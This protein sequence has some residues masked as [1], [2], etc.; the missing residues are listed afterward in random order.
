MRARRVDTNHATVKKAFKKMGC[1]ILDLFRVGDGCPDLLI[2]VSGV[3]QLVEV[4]SEN[5]EVEWEQAEF[6]AEW[7]G[8]KPVVIR[9]VEEAVLLVADMGERARKLRA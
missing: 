9:T 4:K 5:G 7:R 6:H 8:A 1:S 2:A 3:D